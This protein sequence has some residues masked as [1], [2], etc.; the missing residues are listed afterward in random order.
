M[1]TGFMFEHSV[2]KI[3]TRGWAKHLDRDRFEVFGYY[4]GVRED[5][6]TAEARE[7]FDAFRQE[8]HDFHALCRSVKEDRLDVLIYPDIGMDPTC[9]KLAGLRLAPVQCVSLGH[10]M[11]TGLPT[12]DY[13]LS[14]EL[15]EPEDGDAAYTETL[16]RLPNLSV[17]YEPLERELPD[18]G[19]AHFGFPED[20]ILYFCP[21]SLFKYLPQ[22]DLL[23]PLVAQQ[24]PKARFVFIENGHADR[25]N[26]RFLARIART[27][28]EHGLRAAD[29]VIM[30]PYQTP[31]AYRALNALCDVFLDSIKWSGFNSTVEA[32]HAG[33]PGITLPL[34]MMRG[35]HSRAVY[36]MMG[37]EDAIAA[38]FDDYL[39]LAVR[40]GNDATFRQTM[41]SRIEKNR[42]H[43][44]GD[45]EAVR[46]LEAF[47]EKAVV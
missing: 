31:E 12:I 44:F 26:Q 40:M 43:I 7:I 17:H 11:T 28:A 23:F 41:R 21:Q 27:F 42:S 37:M 5:H 24:V 29:H 9:A 15:M 19:R 46:G 33:L 39:G 35:R 32:S 10:P 18:L 6:C 20:A 30:L 14:S 25:L 36:T 4:T 8:P 16:I 34:G 3:P 13:F 38:S 22:F 45:M 1:V 2:W 47:I